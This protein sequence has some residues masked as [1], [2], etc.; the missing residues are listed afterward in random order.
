M[1]TIDVRL[2]FLFQVYQIEF[3]IESHRLY[4]FVVNVMLTIDV[5]FK[6]LFQVYQTEFSIESLRLYTFV[7]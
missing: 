4:K 5:R 2:K 1:L 7:V 3:P 6:F